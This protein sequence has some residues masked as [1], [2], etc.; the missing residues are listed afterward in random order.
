MGFS[1]L[2]LDLG[3]GVASGSYFH[4]LS[5]AALTQQRCKILDYE[6]KPKPLL[7]NP[8]TAM[9]YTVCIKL[10]PEYSCNAEPET[11]ILQKCT[12]HSGFYIV[13]G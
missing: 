7:H 8:K 3:V 12:T 11:I 10:K 9:H 4:I 6:G 1:V 5:R 2:D 13:A